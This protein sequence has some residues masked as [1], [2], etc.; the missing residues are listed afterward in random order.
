MSRRGLII[1]GSVAGVLAV[2]VAIGF[3]VVRSMAPEYRTTLLVDSSATNAADFDAL[4]G[5]VAAVTDDAGDHDALALRRFGGACGDPHATAQLVRSGTGNGAK[6][7]AAV[8]RLVPAGRA[9]LGGGVL[10]AIHDFTGRFPQRGTKRN[11]IVVVT[12]HGTDACTSDTAALR[13][14]IEARARKA[15]LDLQFR[16]VGYKVAPQ[17]QAALTQLASAG[18]GRP[19]F[20][21]NRTDL[22]ATLKKFTVPSSGEL[23][24]I[25]VPTRTVTAEPCEKTVDGAQQPKPAPT[26]V[27][28][29]S[30][31]VLPPRARVYAAGMYGTVAEYL[32]G[33]AAVCDNSYLGLSS[34]TGAW[35]GSDTGEGV[36]A[37]FTAGGVTPRMEIACS[38]FGGVASQL[39]DPAYGTGCTRHDKG[40]TD[41]PT[42]APDFYAATGTIAIAS[43]NSVPGGSVGLTTLS[44]E[45]GTP[46]PRWITCTLPRAAAATCTAALTYFLV[47]QSAGTQVT[48]ASLDAMSK[49]VGAY[50][51]RT[52]TR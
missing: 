14:T 22:T 46:A 38:V 30:Q 29:P 13:R 10:A 27:R 23:Q 19:A 9:T 5:A 26:S 39:R 50:V 8:R 52:L 37:W 40:S 28:L 44:F 16:F 41:L 7:G 47:Q 2:V 1:A 18:G 51:A 34:G 35:I 32:I 24:P 15:G 42:G 17:E 49:A 45:Q 36:Q 4:R 48:S 11:R 43:R 20:V 21:D 3:F 33:P 6:I 31:V 12:S 25:A